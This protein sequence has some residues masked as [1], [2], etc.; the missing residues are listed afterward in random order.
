MAQNNL[1]Q[2]AA[3]ESLM[4]SLPQ[5]QRIWLVTGAAGFIGSHLVE[6][7]LK[8]G[9]RVVGFDNFSTGKKS[10]LEEVRRRVG[11]ESWSSFEMNEGDLNEFRAIARACEGV[12]V[13]LHQAALGSVPASIEYPIK[14]H[15]SNVTGFVNLLE[16]ARASSVKRVV[17]AS[18]S[19]VYGDCPE[20]PLR[21]ESAGGILSPYGPASGSTK[22]TPEPTL[23]VMGWS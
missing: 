21:E 12:D 10:N 15:E 22:F 23:G 2:S 19:S 13:I 4:A 14:T 5:V 20:L 17:Y 11:E 7:L 8:E 18:S 3:S 6:R 1:T 16:A 9:Q